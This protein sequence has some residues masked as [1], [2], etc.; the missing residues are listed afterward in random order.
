MPRNVRNA[1]IDVEIDGQRSRLKGGPKN[2]NGGLSATLFVRE[3]GTVALGCTMSAR[4]VTLPEGK[5]MIRVEILHRDGRN[6]L[7]TFD[8]ER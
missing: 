2:A 8:V 4:P 1:W 3:R 5:T 6:V 7:A